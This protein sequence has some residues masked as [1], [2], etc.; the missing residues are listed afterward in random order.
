M[1]PEVRELERT[2]LRAA[3]HFHQRGYEA[4]SLLALAALAAAQDDPR[5]LAGVTGLL[6]SFVGAWLFFGADDEVLRQ[7]EEAIGAVREAAIAD[8]SE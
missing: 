8:D 1:L 3:L 2:F 4:W 7:C 6:R 5:T